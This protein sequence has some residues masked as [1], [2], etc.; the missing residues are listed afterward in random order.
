MAIDYTGGT[1]NHGNSGGGVVYG[2]PITITGN[3]TVTTIG[4]NYFGAGSGNVR[5]ALY[6]AGVGKPANLLTESATVAMNA[7][8]GW[9]DI[10]VTPY[11][12]VAGSYWVA[13]QFGSARDTYYDSGSF[14]YYFKAYGAFDAVW[15]AGST[16][17]TG[18]QWNMRVTYTAAGWTGKISG[19]TN[20]A[21]IMEVDVANIAT[22]KGVA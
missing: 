4:V 2:L 10:P 15:S 5:V 11:A 14:S 1:T 19:V 18:A 6:S 7:G 12:I 17:D 16:E 3:G 22:I 21:K 20:P 9:Q 13:I 8:A